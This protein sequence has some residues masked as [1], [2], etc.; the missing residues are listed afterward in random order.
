MNKNLKIIIVTCILFIIH[1]QSNAQQKLK[2]AL[3]FDQASKGLMYDSRITNRMIR[4]NRYIDN[5]LCNGNTLDAEVTDR[6]A[7]KSWKAPKNR[8]STKYLLGEYDAM[9][10]VYVE[11]SSIHGLFEQQTTLPSELNHLKTECGGSC[12]DNPNMPTLEEVGKPDIHIFIVDE[13]KGPQDI[14]LLPASLDGNDL[15]VA[16]VKK[17]YWQ[18]TG[19]A[20]WT[21][22]H[23]LV[24]LLVPNLDEVVDDPFFSQDLF[25]NSIPFTGSQ[26]TGGVIEDSDENSMVN[27]AI[28]NALNN[29]SFLL[30]VA[31]ADGKPIKLKRSVSDLYGKSKMVVRGGILIDGSDN[32]NPAKKQ[33]LLSLDENDN[34]GNGAMLF[35]G[36]QV[37]NGTP[38]TCINNSVNFRSV[39]DQGINESVVEK[40]ADKIISTPLTLYP[41]PFTDSFKVVYE[42]PENS[43][44]TVVARVYDLSGRMALVR[45]F[46][47]DKSA[48]TVLEIDGSNLSAGHYIIELIDGSGIP[49]RGKLIKER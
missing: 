34:S 35:I 49:K 40:Q 3:Y 25:Y 38:L 15:S 10:Q 14:Y 1:Y 2:I 12:I 18:S 48:S 47:V 46:D 24:G 36:E 44:G 27:Q 17:S 9:R 29:K 6:I 30:P 4:L 43:T 33:K 41:N 28:A 22:N 8:T 16:V 23:I 32:S 26:S 39:V 7:L 19:N 20:D 42:Q 31:S 5:Q 45:K 37:T 21:L 11:L 13:T